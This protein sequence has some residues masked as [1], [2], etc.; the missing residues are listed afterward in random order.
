VLVG[1][2]STKRTKKMGCRHFTTC[3]LNLSAAKLTAILLVQFTVIYVIIQMRDSYSDRFKDL[4]TCPTKVSN[5][6]GKINHKEYSITEL[7]A[8][9]VKKLRKYCSGFKKYVV[10]S[11]PNYNYYGGG[12]TNWI[13]MT[14]PHHH[15]F[16]CAT[17]KCGSTTW[18]SYLMK[19]LKI[20][21]HN[22]THE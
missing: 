16:Y 12:L 1:C 11:Y 7:S 22:D 6:T 14:S 21:W 10:K 4:P 13:W 3:Y 5:N 20:E 8:C 15:L 19:D 2:S 17:A 18:K 9:R